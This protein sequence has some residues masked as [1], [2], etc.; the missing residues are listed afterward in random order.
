MCTNN[1]STDPEVTWLKSYDSTNM[2]LFGTFGSLLGHLC[3]HISLLPCPFGMF[4][5]SIEPKKSRCVWCCMPHI[6]R[7][8]KWR[9]TRQ[10]PWNTD[11]PLGSI[12]K[13]EVEQKWVPGIRKSSKNTAETFLGGRKVGN[14]V[15]FFWERRVL[16]ESGVFWRGKK[17]GDIGC[18][19][20]KSSKGEHFS[21]IDIRADL[22]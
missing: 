22:R 15:R 19:K 1:P 14:F 17:S 2:L 9:V 8:S 10:K 16:G 7:K 5:S 12:K 3:H 21:N 13:P 20:I 6:K 11:L 4:E 18:Q